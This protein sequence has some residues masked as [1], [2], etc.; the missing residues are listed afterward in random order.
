V[1]LAILLPFVTG[2]H[3]FSRLC[4]WGTLIAGIPWVLW[5][6]VDEASGLPVIEPGMVGWLYALKIGVLLGFLVLFVIT[7][8]P[9]CR[10]FCPLGAIY[11]LF[12]RISVMRLS[13][14]GRCVDCDLCVK[15]CPVGLRVSDDPNSPDCIRCLKCTVC[16]NVHVRWEFG[17]DRIIR[18]TLPSSAQG[19]QGTG[20]PGS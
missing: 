15:A 2:D 18:S 10:T 5:N 16:K 6:P 8:R 17:D 13:V 19:G 3:W 20:T 4:P 14:E 9:F 7:Q 11:S 12:N 1:A